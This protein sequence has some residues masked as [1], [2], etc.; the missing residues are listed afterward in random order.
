[1]GPRLRLSVLPL[2]V[3]LAAFL[4]PR[5]TVANEAGPACAPE[6]SRP[7]I[8]LARPETGRSF[9]RLGGPD[10]FV[11]PAVDRA[12]VP[13]RALTE[14][15]APG[16]GSVRWESDTRTATFARGP[17]LLSISIPLGRSRT[18][19]A[20]VNGRAVQVDTFICDGHLY[21]PARFAAA[22]LGAGI[23]WYPDRTVIIDPAWTP[24][25]ADLGLR[26]L[27][28]R[29]SGDYHIAGRLQ[30]LP[31]AAAAPSAGEPDLPAAPAA[32]SA[33]KPA[34][35][36]A[37]MPADCGRWPATWLEFLSSPARSSRQAVRASACAFV[38][39]R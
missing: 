26:E 33:A 12:I 9:A 21:A 17:H 5:P 24:N 27:P 34:L 4:L 6:G 2:L 19:V 20:V 14:A 8:V 37:A 3:S 16:E 32:P 1:M 28:T 29:P 25:P 35:P 22:A 7:L 13:I 39:A 31:A 30:A 10:S 23:R 15:L 11:D 38:R 36:A 18:G